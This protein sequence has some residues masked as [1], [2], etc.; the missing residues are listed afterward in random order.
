MI[1][2]PEKEFAFFSGLFLLQK[3]ERI[4]GF[5]VLRVCQSNCVSVFSS[6]F[7]VSDRKKLA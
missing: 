2:S 4:I 5:V 3:D 1:H 6:P 7:A